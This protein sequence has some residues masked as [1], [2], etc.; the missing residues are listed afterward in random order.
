MGR[1]EFHCVHL[2][3]SKHSQLCIYVW[4]CISKHQCCTPRVRLAPGE[5]RLIRMTPGSLFPGLASGGGGRCSGL[6]LSVWELSVGALGLWSATNSLYCFQIVQKMTT[7]VGCSNSTL[8]LLAFA[9]K[10]T[11]N[12]PQVWSSFLAAVCPVYVAP[13]R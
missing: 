6:V 3:Y 10:Q 4:L 1:Y 8:A 7:K 5:E 12:C 11:S 13:T 9:V 2:Q